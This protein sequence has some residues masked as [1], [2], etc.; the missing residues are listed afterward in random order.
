[1]KATAREVTLVDTSEAPRLSLS[2]EVPID[3]MENARSERR[4]E[5]EEGHTGAPTGIWAAIHPRLCELVSGSTAA[6]SQRT[7]SR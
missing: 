4:L 5:H 1:M 7:S 6:P 3:E 2:T